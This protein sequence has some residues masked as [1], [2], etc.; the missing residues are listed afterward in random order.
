MGKKKG[1]ETKT[2]QLPKPS[3]HQADRYDKLVK[4]VK[5]LQKLTK[6]RPFKDFYKSVIGKRETSQTEWVDED[7]SR[8]IVRH[9]ETV[10]IVNSIIDDLRKPVDELN[11][12]CNGMPLLAG[13]HPMRADFDEATGEVE[14][15]E[16]KKKAG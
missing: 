4:S 1:E 13:L 2:R 9:Q 11:D 7:K 16:E 3:K 6:L 5:E 15:K 8:E 14:L 12:F 10:R